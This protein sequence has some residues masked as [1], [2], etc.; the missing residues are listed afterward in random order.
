[1]DNDHTPNKSILRNNV[2]D[3]SQIE[4]DNGGNFTASKITHVI[5]IVYIL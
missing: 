5:L 2:L 4:D 3:Y 1:M